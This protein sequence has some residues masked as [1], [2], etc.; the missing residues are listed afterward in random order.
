MEEADGENALYVSLVVA[1]GTVTFL[2][3]DRRAPWA[4]VIQAR[5]ALCKV[6]VYPPL[7]N[8]GGG[9][10]AAVLVKVGPVGPVSTTESCLI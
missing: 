7:C 2:T 6:T 5:R 8:V 4:P 1:P 10:D 9:R 3:S